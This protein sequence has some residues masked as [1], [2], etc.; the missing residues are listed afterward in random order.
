MLP[1]LLAHSLFDALSPKLVKTMLCAY[2]VLG[3]HDVEY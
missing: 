2:E 3:F 1:I